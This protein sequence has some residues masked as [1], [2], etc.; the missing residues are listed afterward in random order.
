MTLSPISPMIHSSSEDFSVFPFL[1]LTVNCLFWVTYGMLIDDFVILMLNAV[2]IVLSLFYHWLIFNMMEGRVS[3]LYKFATCIAI[4]VSGMIFVL[5][6]VDREYMVS[7]LGSICALA[8]ITM[9][10]SPLANI[11]AVL[12]KRNADSIPLL[13]AVAATLNSLN[14]MVYGLVLRDANIYLPNSIGALLGIIQLLLKYLYK[15]N[16]PQVFSLSGSS[17]KMSPI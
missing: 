12:E 4:Y 16:T 6:A 2:G 7:F 8:A 15:S 3:Y 11:K 5:F 13:L 1:C 9:I 14:W 17:N 10:G